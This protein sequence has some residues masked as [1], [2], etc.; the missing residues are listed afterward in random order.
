[1]INK[2]IWVKMSQKPILQL[3][4]R[5]AISLLDMT[6]EQM[7]KDSEFMKN[8]PNDPITANF[9]ILKLQREY[10]YQTFSDMPVLEKHKKPN[11]NDMISP[12]I[13]CTTNGKKK[14]SH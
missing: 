5:N 7:E 2:A 1:M 12:S 14:Y 6:T 10:L 11:Q 3:G 4:I 13:L 9:E 8:Y